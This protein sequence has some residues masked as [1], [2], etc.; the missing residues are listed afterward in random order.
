MSIQV[1]KR[2]VQRLGGS[3][4]IITLPKNWVKKLGLIAGDE[5]IVVDE[6]AHLKILPSTEDTERRLKSLV[7][8]YGSN[9][10]SMRL[11]EIVECAF[12]KGIDWVYLYPSRSTM[13]LVEE[14]LRELEESD[15]VVNYTV[16]P[17][18][19]EIMIN[20]SNSDSATIIKDI[21]RFMLE[22]IDV[23]ENDEELENIFKTIQER[24][25]EITHVMSKRGIISCQ[26]TPMDP[27]A[28]GILKTIVVQ[29]RHLLSSLNAIEDEEEK[30]HLREA[31]RAIILSV[32]GGLSNN[33]IKR[34]GLAKEEIKS[35]KEKISL[36][37]NPAMRG[38]I[39]SFMDSLELLISTASCAIVRGQTQP[40]P[41]YQ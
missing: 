1:T 31:I 34:L 24:I 32:M 3:S 41:G 30:K 19:I 18:R 26:E 35:V 23:S 20:S 28:V 11:S 22:A 4:L 13:S 10:K 37:K 15:Y 27:S 5:V 21:R 14:S 29:F 36:I 39:L 25:N 2:R 33:S 17:D 9:I 40:S 38:F 7:V 8:K 6:G 16:Y 12:S